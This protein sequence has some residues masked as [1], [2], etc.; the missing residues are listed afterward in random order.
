M[1]E[2]KTKRLEELAPGQHQEM[3]EYIVT[4][5]N[6]RQVR[7][8]VSADDWQDECKFMADCID[9]VDCEGITRYGLKDIKVGR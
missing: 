8:L 9:Y 3:T 7:L 1:E 2:K 5:N 6:G 4:M